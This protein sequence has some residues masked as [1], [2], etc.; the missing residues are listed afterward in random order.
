VE[1]QVQE[2][3]R[4]VNDTLRGSLP[5]DVHHAWIEPLAPAGLQ[6]GVLYVRAPASAREWV[7]RRFGALLDATVS[8]D[9]EASRVELIAGDEGPPSSPATHRA[10]KPGYTFDAFVIGAANRFAHAAS[11]AVAELPGQVYNP[12]FICG[13][14]GTGKTHL[15]QAIGNYVSL[16]VSGLTVRY[17][18][19]ETFTSG[20]LAALQRDQLPTFKQHYRSAD[21]LLLD[22]VHF[23]ESK[24][25][26]SEEFLYTLDAALTAGAQVVLS[27]DR[28][29]AAMPHLHAPLKGRF[30]GGLLVE[31]TTPDQATRLGI[32]HREAGPDARVLADN[33]VLRLLA[34]RISTNVRSLQSALVRA[35]AYASLTQEPLTLEL[36]ERVLAAIAPQAPE[37]SS[38]PISIERIQ[39]RT[40]LA[41]RLEPETLSSARRSRQVVYARQI[42]MYLCRELTDYSLPAIARRFGGRDHTT[43]LHAHRKVQRELLVNERTRHVVDDLVRELKGS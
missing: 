8:A 21:V 2:I 22:D 13:P 9:T 3:W 33:G 30:E 31:V 11:L 24:E 27:A 37:T 42:A 23:L 17:A 12:L 4:H 15:L 28:P 32:L 34:H 35:R 1:D 26:T 5:P 36:A 43:V 14:P 10:L 7:R 16:C 29:P 41:L 18:S 6:G 20:F 38:S 25:R 19:A 40:S 39:D